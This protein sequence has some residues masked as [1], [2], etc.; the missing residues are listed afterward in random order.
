[1]KWLR[2]YDDVLDDPKVQRLPAHL[3]KAWINLLCL[4]NKSDERGTLPC[5]ED[6]AFRLR[7]KPSEAERIMDALEQAGLMER[8]ETGWQ[9]HQWENR[10]RRSDDVA[11][12][13]RTWRAENPR[14]NSA[15]A[16]RQHR[17]PLKES[18]AS[19][20]KAPECN[21][22]RNVVEAEAEAEKEADI[23]TEQQQPGARA[24]EEVLPA[25]LPA[26]AAA[27]PGYL[28]NTAPAVQPNPSE[29][30]FLLDTGFAASEIDTAVAAVQKRPGFQPV[31]D[32]VK[33]L[34]GPL[35][36]LRRAAAPS[37][38]ARASPHAPTPEE[39]AARQAQEDEARRNREE[40]LNKLKAGAAKRAAQENAHANGT[41][42]AGSPPDA[43]AQILAG[44]S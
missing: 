29:R 26:A 25:A 30:K 27:V 6:I 14:Q 20:S 16:P 4:A 36:D 21:V 12:R 33:Y 37:A 28:K 32:W 35:D 24:C 9:P 19:I 40:A 42:R 34:Q 15:P 8:A 11:E 31:R 1:M 2:L 41:Q 18:N 13:V 22:T 17:L 5:T 7:L 10:Q 38:P 43:V 44:A 23:D 39:I 3:F